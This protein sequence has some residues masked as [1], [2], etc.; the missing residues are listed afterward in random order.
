MNKIWYIPVI[1]FTRGFFTM[2]STRQNINDRQAQLMTLLK[3][4]GYCSI[5]AMGEQL[6][7]SQMTVRRDLAVLQQQH[8]VE[9]TYG[10]ARFIA[11]E[12]SEPDFAT[13]S[14]AYL[15]A[16]QAIGKRA[17]KS[18][19]AGDVIGLDSGSTLVEVARNLPD[20]PLTVVTQ[21]LPVANIVARNERQQLILLGGTFQPGSGYFYGPQAV[22]ALHSLYINK[23]FLATSGLLLPSTLCSSY[24]SDA[25]MKQALI[26]ASHKIILCMD[27][28]KI[29]RAFLARFASLDRVDTLITDDGI[30]EQQRELIEQQVRIVEVRT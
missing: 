17:A 9:V 10:G 15:E 7:V 29:D 6:H 11:S 28:S 4:Q 5:A 27:S 2:T 24:L 22:A 16:K 21:S 19:E 23:L 18:I 8:I 12:H 20:V 14:H 3:A 30:T 26:D 13:R 25:E 1:L